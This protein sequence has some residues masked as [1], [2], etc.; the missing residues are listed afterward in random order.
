[1]IGSLNATLEWFDTKRGNL[2]ELADGYADIM[3]HGLLPHV[4]LDP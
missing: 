2:A 3:L 4:E 1:L